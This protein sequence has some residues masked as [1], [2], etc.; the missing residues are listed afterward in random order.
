[1]TKE[2]LP[3]GTIPAN[4][5]PFT[6]DLDIDEAGLRRHLSWL[7]AVPKVTAIVQNGHAAEVSSLDRDEKKRVMA[8]TMSEVGDRLPIIAGVDADGSLEAAQQAKDAKEEGARAILVLPPVI[9][10]RGAELRPQTAYAHF[11]TIAD[12][13]DIPLVIFQYPIGQGG[14][15]TDTLVMLAEKIPQIVGIKDGS[16]DIVVFERNLRALHSLPRKFSVLT[17]YTTALYSTLLLGSDGLISGM[18]S[19]A[20]DLQAELFATVQRTDLK[21]A[22]EINSRL[23]PMCQVFYKA[24]RLDMHNRMKEALVMLGRLDRAVVRP[25]LVP[26]DDSER[27]GIRRA[28]IKAK[29]LSAIP[30]G[31]RV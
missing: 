20:A 19:V 16:S 3:T 18:G 25:P 22:Q 9:F 8:I 24:P 23:F 21:K 28:L 11:A 14:Y 29:L 5:L 12:K 2:Y 26:I 17:T 30:S 27:E 15:T 1:M 31:A 13:A 7:A 6:E 10:G 4:L